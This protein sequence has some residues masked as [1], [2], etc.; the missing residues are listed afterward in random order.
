MRKWHLQ[1]IG[2][3]LLIILLAGCGGTGEG[4]K[5]ERNS[6]AVG[7]NAST[8]VEDAGDAFPKTISHAK[9]E[10]V[11][12]SRPETV[13][14][15]YFP[16]A[17]HLFAIDEA[18]LVGGVVGLTSMQNFPVY[19]PFLADGEIVDLGNEAN[20]EKIVALNPDVIIASEMDENIYDQ[21]EKI[22][23]TIVIPMSEN[24]QETI[25]QVAAV[26]GEEDGAQQYIERFNEQLGDIAAVMEQTGEKGKAALFMMTWGKGFN[27]YSGI[28][29]KNYY[30]EIGFE[31]Y[32]QLEDYGEIS[33]EGVSEL[34]P[35]YIFLGEDFTESAELKLQELEE[36]SVWN[37]L[38][39]VKDGNVFIVDTEMMGP[40][41][42]GQSKG[43]EIIEHIL[44]ETE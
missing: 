44:M 41:A 26:V 14:V 30:E 8:S 10:A 19:D 9:G 33:L 20:L 29:M 35:D 18:S 21:L 34:N 28:R 38:T 12:E 13:A 42:M 4:S 36:N 27:Y 17:E 6:D 16:Y 3:M 11:I 43:L 37:Q 2:T 7:E 5:T 31:K 32:D 15:L 40:L 23:E 39:A 22:A 25:V 24:W 1:L